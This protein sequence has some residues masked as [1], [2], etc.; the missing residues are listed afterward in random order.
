MAK[1]NKEVEMEEIEEEVPEEEPVPEP[2]PQPEPE[3]EPEP[4]PEVK[5]E[6]K[7]VYTANGPMIRLPDGSMTKTS[8]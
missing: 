1:K 5:G 2:E 3:P 4:I 6:G 7:L 8:E